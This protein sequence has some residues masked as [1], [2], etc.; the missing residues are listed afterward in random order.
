MR[1]RTW[2]LLLTR[3]PTRYRLHS[4]GGSLDMLKI[5][6]MYPV[7]LGFLIAFNCKEAKAGFI[8]TDE[9]KY[10]LMCKMQYLGSHPSPSANISPSSWIQQCVAGYKKKDQEQ[11][12]RNREFYNRVTQPVRQREQEFLTCM[13]S[14]RGIQDPAARQAQTMICRQKLFPR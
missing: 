5:E 9:A 11:Y 10:Q 8:T 6:S 13:S 1:K 3:S 14:V 12:D 2:P 4:Q 7:L